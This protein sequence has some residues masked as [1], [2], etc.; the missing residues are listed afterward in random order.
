V[1]RY[2]ERRLKRT[3]SHSEH[4]AEPAAEKQQKERHDKRPMPLTP[5]PL[6]TTE[7]I[8]NT[9]HCQNRSK[10]EAPAEETRSL[11]QT[12]QEQVISDADADTASTGLELEV[13]HWQ[14]KESTA[15]CR[16]TRALK[17]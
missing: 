16:Y 17:L 15:M 7:K 1:Q 11:L 12:I 4:E 3:H 8:D 5:N 2:T 14:Q 13:K 6:G 9:P 10:A